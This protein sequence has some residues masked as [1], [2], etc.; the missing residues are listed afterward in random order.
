VY[1]KNQ[2]IESQSQKQT[3]HQPNLANLKS[4]HFKKNPPALSLQK[5]K[6]C[7]ALFGFL[8]KI[9]VCKKEN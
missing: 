4:M 2:C 5:Q 1:L 3:K 8:K 9:L 6:L 7:M